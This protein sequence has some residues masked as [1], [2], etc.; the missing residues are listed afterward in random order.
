MIA[1]TKRLTRREGIALAV[2]ILGT[3][4]LS[5]GIASIL[6]FTDAIAMGVYLVLTISALVAGAVGCLALVRHWR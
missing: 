2:L 4:V 1:M 3:M 5:P 6:Y